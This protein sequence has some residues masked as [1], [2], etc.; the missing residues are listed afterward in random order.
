MPTA[1]RERTL[2]IDQIDLTVIDR[3]PVFGATPRRAFVN[4]PRS[5]RTGIAVASIR[6]AL[7]VVLA[8]TAIL[9]LL[10][11]MIAAQAAVAI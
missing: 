3:D 1:A 6:T 10:P 4:H 5:G 2:T 8:G 7:M 11:A 9:V